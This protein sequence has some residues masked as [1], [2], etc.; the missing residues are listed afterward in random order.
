MKKFLILFLFLSM[1]SSLSALNPPDFQF[2]QKIAFPGYVGSATLDGFPVLLSFT[3]A[4]TNFYFGLASPSGGDLRFSDETGANDVSHEIEIWDTNGTS[5]V[6]VRVPTLSSN[7]CIFMYWGNPSDTNFPPSVTNGSVWADDYVVVHHLN[8]TNGLTAPDATSNHFD[9][10][11]R[12]MSGAEWETGGLANGLRFDGADDFYELPNINAFFGGDAATLN[13]WVKLDAATPAGGNQT[14]FM[15]LGSGSTCAYPW[16]N[17]LSFQNV[18]R[19]GN[20]IES[21]ALLPCIDRASW[22]QVSITSET[23]G[24]GRWIMYQNGIEIRNEAAEPLGIPTTPAIGRFDPLYLD[25]ML[26]ELRISNVARSRK[27]IQTSW[28]NLASNATFSRFEPIEMVPT[29]RPIVTSLPATNLSDTNAFLNAVLISTGSAATAVAVYYGANDLGQTPFGWSM[30]NDF[31]GTS[32]APPVAYSHLATGLTPSQEYVYRYVATNAAGTWWSEPQWFFTEGP[33]VLNLQTGPTNPGLNSAWINGRY[34]TPSRGHVTMYYGSVDGGTNPAA[35]NVSTNLGS[36]TGRTFSTLATGLFYGVQYFYQASGTNAYGEGWASTS[37]A[38][39]LP[40]PGGIS[41][42]NQGPMNITASSAVIGVNVAAPASVFHLLAYWGPSDG[43]TGSLAWSNSMSVG[44]FTNTASTNLTLPINGLAGNRSYWNTFRMTNCAEDLWG[45]PAERFFTLGGPVVVTNA[46]GATGVRSGGATL[47]GALTSGGEADISIF[48]GTSDGGTN[49]SAWDREFFIGARLQVGFAQSVTGLLYGIPYYYRCYATNPLDEA[50]AAATESFKTPAP[51]ITPDELSGL[52]LWLNASTIGSNDNDIVGFWPDDSGNGHHMDVLNPGSD[53]RYLANGLNGRPV[54]HYDGDD[55]QYVTDD[56]S[57]I[58]DHTIFSV[59]RYAGAL[60]RR[61]ISAR[62]GHNWLVGF[63]NN[64]DERWYSEGF[65]HSTGNNNTNW[66]L[67]AGTMTDEPDP[68]AAFWKDG[69]LL[70]TNSTASGPPHAPRQIAFGAGFNVTHESSV[71]E[72]AELIIFDRVLD[73]GERGAMGGYL[74]GKYGLGSTYPVANITGIDNRPAAGVTKTTAVIRARLFAPESVFH[75]YAYWNTVDGG[76]NETLW[77]HSAF[78]GSFTNTSLTNLSF[79]VGGLVSNTDYYF[80]FRMTNCVEDTWAQPAGCLQTEGPPTVDNGEGAIDAGPGSVWLQG[81]LTTGGVA[82]S[83]FF[84]GR[85]NGGTVS[86]AWD[87]ATT[88]TEIYKGGFSNAVSNL[89]F[90]VP[91]YYRTWVTNGG[92]ADWADSSTNFKTPPVIPYRLDNEEVTGLTETSAVLNAT[93]TSSQA[94][95]GVTV[96]WGPSDGGT[97]HFAW[98]NAFH[99]GV[100][101]N[102]AGLFSHPIEGLNIETPYFFRFRATNC[103]DDV[104]TPSESFFTLFD[105]ASFSQQIK[106]SFCGYD[107]A[108]S[109]TNFPA[110]VVLGTNISGFSYS[111]FASASGGDLRFMDGAQARALSY[112]VEVWNTDG[113]SHIWVRVPELVDSNTCI[114]AL[115]GNANTNPPPSTSNGSVWDTNYVMVWHLNETGGLNIADATALNNDGTMRNIEDGDWTPGLVGRGID[116]DGVDEYGVRM[117]N[118]PETELT[119]S[120]WVRTTADNRGIFSTTFPE[121]GN[122]SDRHIHLSNGGVRSRIWNNQAIVTPNLNLADG[123]WHQVVRVLGPSAGGQRVYIDGVEQ[124]FGNRAVSDFD[125]DTHIQIGYC[126]DALSDYHQGM[127]DEFRTS[128]T[129]REPDWIWASWHNVASND[130][131]ICYSPV[132]TSNVDLVVTKLASTTNLFLSS[133]LTYTIQVANAGLGIAAGVVVTD[134]LPVGVTLVSSVPSPVQT[135]GNDYSFDLG[136]IGAGA[137]F[138]IVLQVGVTGMTPFVVTNRAV[139]AGAIPEASLVNNVD[140]AVTSILD[141]DGDGV[142]NP[143]DPDDDDDGVPDAEEVI[144]H[145]DPFDPTSFLW[146]RIDRTAGLNAQRLTFMTSRGRTYRIESSTNLYSNGWNVIQSNLPGLG[147]VTNLTVTN[148]NPRIYFRLGVE[149]P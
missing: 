113:D 137:S 2:R 48:F 69:V 99:L 80:T 138:S 115:W 125:W 14:G 148:L 16:V 95:W 47:N 130:A 89:L 37:T 112:E 58:G 136:S 60:S 143:F 114:F 5:M 65:I 66:H 26:D 142:T 18:W 11:L 134:T 96:Y 120:M 22:H 17:S 94:V 53:P 39:K 97:N 40:R 135:N 101:T 85:S 131:F 132:P 75:I 109:L 122:P 13:V 90:G 92:G 103:A 81:D 72:I 105:A 117:I 139:A 73:A 100:F 43:G 82:F 111:Q 147:T 64:G 140:R 19:S 31:G 106:L 78:V 30:T 44:V 76:T 104:W 3:P 98:S 145:T 84:W 23:G 59:A 52:E 118:Q 62:T 45:E 24:S 83:R 4:L 12:N 35:W 21:I 144:A 8:E 6:W 86:S 56:I 28:L 116:F 38:F 7:A 9:G 108:S 141:A 121:Q 15:T 110:L 119:H 79:P 36:V 41:L 27:W 149:S 93:L 1:A 77:T 49:K 74:E 124:A 51:L 67:H 107:R 133:N 128:Y 91:Y 50:W 10:A 32:A 129:V 70:T 71:A 25:G 88:L 146:I 102:M 123:Q 54:V 20:R 57:F 63:W 34:A 68:R 127:M 61:V 55:Y 29:N 42:V 46:V 126:I 33:P 87:N